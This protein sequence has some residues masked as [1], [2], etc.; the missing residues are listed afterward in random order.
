[1]ATV[2]KKRKVKK[3]VWVV[4]WILC[5]PIPLT[6]II[7]R[8]ARMNKIIKGI[9]I[10]FLWFFVF[11]WT[12]SLATYETADD[13]TMTISSSEQV[14]SAEYASSV[15]DEVDY[16]ETFMEE[17]GDTGVTGPDNV[18]QDVTGKWRIT[19]IYSDKDF[20]PYAPDYYH[21]YFSSD[22]EI[23]AIINL[24]LKT[25]TKLTVSGVYLN[26]TVYEYVDG[27]EHSANTLFSGMQYSSYVIN[28]VTGDYEKYETN[29]DYTVVEAGDSIEDASRR[30]LDNRGY[31]DYIVRMEGDTL[32][33]EFQQLPS[34]AGNLASKQIAYLTTVSFTDDFL[35][36]YTN[37]DEWEMI[38]VRYDGVGEY[39]L[40]KDL[41]MDSGG[42][43]RFF[44]FFAD[45]II[46][47]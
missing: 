21:G 9:L 25:T 37:D 20:I 43:G 8:N 44:N 15:I 35:E 22:D 19:L 46:D 33:V 34:S 42:Y 3:W 26:A 1:M 6:A 47:N 36:Q 11:V 10:S 38:I 41:I 17:M 24:Y 4:G 32:I 12:A 7:V 16:K 23:H 40:T 28:K 31:T 18:Y 2:K 45:D 30:L 39:R 5:F 13:S 14:S 29:W 27:E